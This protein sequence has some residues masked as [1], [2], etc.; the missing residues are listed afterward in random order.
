MSLRLRRVC[1]HM[2]TAEAVGGYSKILYWVVCVLQV[3]FFA[4]GPCGMASSDPVHPIWARSQL[5]GPRSDR[6]SAISRPV[7]TRGRGSRGPPGGILRVLD[8]ESVSLEKAHVSSF[9]GPRGALGALDA[10]GILWGGLTWIVP[11]VRPP[12]KSSRSPFSGPLGARGSPR[13]ARGPLGSLGG[14]S[15]G[16]C[17]ESGPF[18]KV[19]G[20]SFS[21]QKDKNP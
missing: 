20:S 8:L 9:S 16:L 2:R 3:F 7:G 10:P 19:H 1:S 6:F 21:V 4:P 13:G 15:P 17:P 14:V 11:R 18:G 12:R 5:G